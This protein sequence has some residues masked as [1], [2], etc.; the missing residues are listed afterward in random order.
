M[1]P[2]LFKVLIPI[3]FSAWHLADISAPHAMILL[4]GTP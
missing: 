1:K 4:A 3:L 2:R